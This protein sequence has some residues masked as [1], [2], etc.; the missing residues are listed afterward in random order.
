[1]TAPS[2]SSRTSAFEAVNLGSN[3]SGASLA[4]RPIETAPKDGTYVLTL[5]NGRPA[6]GYYADLVIYRYG[7]MSSSSQGWRFGMN[8]R[9]GEPTHWLPLPPASGMEAR[10][11]GDAKQTPSSDDSPA[12]E[13]D[14]QTKSVNP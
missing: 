8:G 6:F 7:E 14:A 9:E 4:W 5:L 10:Q 11:G 1:M 3:P 2:S 13:G 12:P